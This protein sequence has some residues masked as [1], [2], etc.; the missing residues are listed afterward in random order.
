MYRYTDTLVMTLRVHN[1]SLHD[2]PHRPKTNSRHPTGRERG[3]NRNARGVAALLVMAGCSGPNEPAG[4]TF[5]VVDSAGIE[6]V[7]SHAPAWTSRQAWRVSNR[8]SLTIGELDGPLEFTFGNVRA[9]GELSD[10]RY[11]VGDEQAHTIHIF[12]SSGDYMGLEVV[13]LVKIV[14]VLGIPANHVPGVL[15]VF[16]DVTAPEPV[17]IVEIVH[18]V[19]PDSTRILHLHY[20]MAARFVLSFSPVRRRGRRIRP[21]P[22]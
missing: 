12:S 2:M 16:G 17:F 22:G 11:F 9:V 14:R 21:G 6:I 8:P 19:S 18:V 3:L 15:V 13:F 10:G 4:P 20:A 7:T 5:A 1:T